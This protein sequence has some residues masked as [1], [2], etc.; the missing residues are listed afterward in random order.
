MKYFVLLIF[1]IGN[2]I[3][4]QQVELPV[5]ENKEICYTEVMLAGNTG[6]KQLLARAMVFFSSQKNCSG[7][8][9]D[10][11]VA[12]T[13]CSTEIFGE[14]FIQKLILSW[15][16]RI[17]FK[18]GRYKYTISDLTYKPVPTT[19]NPQ[20]LEFS[21]NAMYK[22]YIELVNT[23]KEKSKKAKNSESIFKVTD[24]KIREFIDEMKLKLTEEVN[25]QDDW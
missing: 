23:G 4:A 6:K 13:R 22:E 16:V 17:D 1:F 24:R 10:T 2:A 8:K 3:Q 5:N 19:Q 15:N 14:N 18:E 25:D 20:P 7:S 11:L 12:L 9:Y 21:G